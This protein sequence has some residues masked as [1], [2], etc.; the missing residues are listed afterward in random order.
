MLHEDRYGLLEIPISLI[1]V[2][3]FPLVSLLGKFQK[4]MIGSDY[5]CSSDTGVRPLGRRD[6]GNAAQV[7]K[8]TRVTII[9]AAPDTLGARWCYEQYTGVLH[10]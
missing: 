10:V 5:M 2:V 8:Y 1:Y 9:Y 4:S 7:A 3:Y 6:S